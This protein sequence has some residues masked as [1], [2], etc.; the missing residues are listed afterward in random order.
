MTTAN[1]NVQW[2]CGMEKYVFRSFKYQPWVSHTSVCTLSWVILKIYLGKHVWY[3][4]QLHAFCW[5]GTVRSHDICREINSL[6]PRQNGRLFADD[7]FKHIFLNE[8]IIISTKNSLKFVPKGL[9]NKI[10]ALVLIM[11]WCRSGD[12]PLSEPMLVRSLT[13]ICVTRPQWVKYHI[14]VLVI[15]KTVSWRVRCSVMFNSL[16]SGILELHVSRISLKLILVIDGCGISCEFAL[17]WMSQDLLRISRHWFRSMAECHQATCYYLSQWWPAFERRITIIQQNMILLTLKDQYI[18][19]YSNKMRKFTKWI[20]S[21]AVDFVVNT[22]HDHCTGSSSKLYSVL[23]FSLEQ[24]PTAQYQCVN[25]AI[26]I[27]LISLSKCGT[28]ICIHI[29]K[30]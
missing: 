27:E 2:S 1:T 14:L 17:R 7:T 3:G 8:N 29:E 6:R 30:L 13:H 12:K 23:L 20:L 11:A 10:P 24:P 4:S 9:I 18:P 28:S 25:I 15:C 5:L 16:A 22:T 21:L 26:Y 19:V